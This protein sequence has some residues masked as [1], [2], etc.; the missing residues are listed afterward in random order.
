[1]DGVP[2]YGELLQ[3]FQ[4]DT[5]IIDVLYKAFDDLTATSGCRVGSNTDP[6]LGG[7]KWEPNDTFFS[8]AVSLANLCFLC[9]NLQVLLT[10]ESLR[11]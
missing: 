9:D 2:A 11:L 7:C 6:V 1:M 4:H 5:K 3:S 10:R 8:D